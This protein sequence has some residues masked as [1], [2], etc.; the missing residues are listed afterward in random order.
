MNIDC[1]VCTRSTEDNDERFLRYGAT[2]LEPDKTFTSVCY[3]CLICFAD[4]SAA[5]RRETFK[6]PELGESI[7]GTTGNYSAEDW[8]DRT[9]FWDPDQRFVMR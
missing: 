2:F 3:E 6:H 1:D 8:A 9:R 4:V 5:Q 7:M